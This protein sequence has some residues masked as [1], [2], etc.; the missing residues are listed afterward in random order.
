MSLVSA[1][2]F[3]G[4]CAVGSS[5]SANTGASGRG[6]TIPASAA[7]PSSPIIN[8]IVSGAVAGKRRL[9]AGLTSSI[10][11]VKLAS[12]TKV[13]KKGRRRLS[14]CV[15]ASLTTRVRHDVKLAAATK[16]KTKPRS[17]RR[18]NDSGF[19]YGIQEQFFLRD[20]DLEITSPADQDGG[21]ATNQPDLPALLR[22]ATSGDG[23]KL[24]KRRPLRKKSSATLTDIM[25]ETLL[26]LREMREEI[27][28]LREEMKQMKQQMWTTGNGDDE[29]FEDDEDDEQSLL[30]EEEA[31]NVHMPEHH[32]HAQPHGIGGLMARRK[33]YR[34]WEKI[35]QDVEKWADR[36]FF[37]E[38]CNLDENGEGNGWKEIKCARVCRSKFNAHGRFK[39][40][41]KWMPDS[42]EENARDD[43]ERE[44]P[45]VCVKGTIDAPFEHVC[46]Y[47]SRKEYM[48]EYN[49]L[50]I[51]H[52]VLEEITPHS[53][54]TW[55]QSPQILFVK[56][57][58]FVTYCHHRWR[59]DG[60]LVIL[61]QACEHEDAPG[62]ETDKGGK[63]CRALA[64]R[65][66]NYIWKDPEDE[67]K[68]KI[69]LLAH[70]DP[71][72]LPLW[73]C[74]SAVNA[75]APIEPFKLFH[76]IEECVKRHGPPPQRSGFAAALP[77]RSSRPAG[78][79]QMGYACF[80]PLGGGLRE[81]HPHHAEDNEQ[82]AEPSADS[83]LSVESQ[84]DML[85]SE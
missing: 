10:R 44:S 21:S 58:D 79:S 12:A 25:G 70:A 68:T 69:Y 38:T 2:I 14:T 36:L 62:E 32:E 18:R 39:C 65:G 27:F 81:H 71:G 41:L 49:E 29:E 34:M 83:E 54:I 16:V 51:A 78:M 31:A 72:G 23:R 35:G 75:V 60:K 85:P 84:V 33:R 42:R 47:L 77:G 66:A 48:H 37:D 26:E 56:P 9:S 30:L 52:R 43:K 74:K 15:P 24:P 63:V 76:N 8:G 1:A 53:K 46:D 73:A 22:S 55:G 57:R 7:H 82:E 80:W 45:C 11:H 17:K 61:N 13:E 3:I 50:V 20:E 40:Y 59:R 64:L 6:P 5:A 19:Y 67:T 4:V 28:A